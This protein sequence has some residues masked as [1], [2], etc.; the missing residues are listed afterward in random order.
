MIFWEEGFEVV[1]GVAL[2]DGDTYINRQLWITILGPNLN[3]NQAPSSTT[4]FLSTPS[5]TCPLNPFTTRTQHNR[6]LDSIMDIGNS[7]LP[8]VHL[9]RPRHIRTELNCAVGG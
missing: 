4:I 9:V 2:P 8:L 1:F 6:V 3:S 5:S 7:L